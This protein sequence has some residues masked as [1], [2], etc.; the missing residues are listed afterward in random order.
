MVY[1]ILWVRKVDAPL[2]IGKV[3]R[4]NFCFKFFVS[5]FFLSGENIFD[6]NPSQD[7]RAYPPHLLKQ[8][9]IR[10][11]VM[12]PVEDTLMGPY[13]DYFHAFWL[14][15]LFRCTS[16]RPTT[17]SWYFGPWPGSCSFQV[18]LADS[19]LSTHVLTSFQHRCSLA[20]RPPIQSLQ[21]HPLA[22]ENSQ[23]QRLCFWT[24]GRVH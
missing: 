19:H 21:F 20:S 11:G 15:W 23:S 2:T 17:A 18:R 16:N 14:T 12:I 13:L 8:E 5:E 10:S 3:F 24:F 9:V 7:D 6:D 4:R 22:T 1:Q